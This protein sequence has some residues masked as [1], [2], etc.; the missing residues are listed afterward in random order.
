MTPDLAYN[1][2]PW[3]LFLYQSESLQSP[4]SL[5]TSFLTDCPYLDLSVDARSPRR[6][7]ID[8]HSRAAFIPQN[9]KSLCPHQLSKQ[10][11]REASEHAVHRQRRYRRRRF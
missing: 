8:Y 3:N 1:A 7:L 6:V 10:I 9:S 5:L 4:D 11:L 2:V